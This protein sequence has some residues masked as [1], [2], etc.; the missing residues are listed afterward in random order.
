M[1]HAIYL[2]FEIMCF[3]IEYCEIICQKTVFEVAFEVVYNALK[4]LKK[5]QSVGQQWISIGPL[6]IF[7]HP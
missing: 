6:A 2:Y 4:I 1:A 5:M 7:C 3:N